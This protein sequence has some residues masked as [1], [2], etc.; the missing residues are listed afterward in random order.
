MK[1]LDEWADLGELDSVAVN[2][3]RSATTTIAECGKFTLALLSTVQ[4][5]EFLTDFN[6]HNSP[7]LSTQ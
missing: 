5:V 6:P 3:Q 4:L 2:I 7:L 1:F